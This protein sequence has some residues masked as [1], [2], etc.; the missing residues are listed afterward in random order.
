MDLPRPPKSVRRITL[1]QVGDGGE[2]KSLTLF[3]DR[4]KGRQKRGSPLVHE[5]EKMLYTIVKAQQALVNTY[6]NEHKKSNRQ[7][8]DGWLQ[9]LPSNVARASKKALDQMNVDPLS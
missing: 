3:R 5:V 1:L 8:S 9:D 4:S 6:I 2:I 7:K